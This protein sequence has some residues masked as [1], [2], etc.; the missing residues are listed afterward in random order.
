MRTGK[1]RMRR[2]KGAFTWI[3]A[4]TM[5]AASIYSVSRWMEPPPAKS[6]DLSELYHQAAYTVIPK[7]TDISSDDIPPSEYEATKGQNG[8]GRLEIEE[9]Q[10]GVGRSEIEEQKETDTSEMVEE[11]ESYDYT[12]PVPE[13]DEVEDSYFSDAIF[14][15]NSRT[16]GFALYAGLSGIRAYTAR[17][18]TVGTVFTDPVINQNGEKVSIMDAIKNGPAF[19]KAYIMLGINELGWSYSSLFIEKYGEVIDALLAINPNVT[20]YVQSILPVTQEKSDADRIYN[21]SKIDT[22]NTLLREMCTE[23]EVYYVNV[24]EGVCDENGVLP[25]DASFDGVHLNRESCKKW[26]TYLKTHT[27]GVM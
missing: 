15:G 23:K 10:N 25:A 22:F 27:V 8:A 13:S 18:A 14:I 2:R 12:K 7:L 16:E 6:I 4:V 5:T 26:L 20:I 21:N 24:A 19:S 9:G 1:R 3:V 11:K 17:G